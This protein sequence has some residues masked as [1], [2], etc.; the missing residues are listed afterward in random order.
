MMGQNTMV[1]LRHAL[2]VLAAALIVASTMAASAGPAAAKRNC[3]GSILGGLSCQGGESGEGN[4]GNLETDPLNQNDLTVDF[5][6][7]GHQVEE[8]GSGTP[9]GGN[10]QGTVGLD[11]SFQQDCKGAADDK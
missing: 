10:C 2:L 8:A 7:R 4:G 1:A 11:G 9:K 5:H 3:E 6:K